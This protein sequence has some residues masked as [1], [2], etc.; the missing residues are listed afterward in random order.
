M[1][2]FNSLELSG[3]NLLTAVGN[4][5]RKSY[6]DLRIKVDAMSTEE[7]RQLAAQQF[8]GSWL[9]VAPDTQLREAILGAHEPLLPGEYDLAEASEDDLWPLCEQIL[10]R[11]P[12]SLNPRVEPGT[13]RKAWLAD[14]KD[15][16][17][18]GRSPREAILR[19]YVTLKLGTEV[20]LN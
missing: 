3:D 2:T 19:F 9:S 15:F 5:L 1:T 7:L 14:D 11:Y 4:A 17:V 6:T 16:R 18:S 20:T 8:H 13:A 10:E 12:V